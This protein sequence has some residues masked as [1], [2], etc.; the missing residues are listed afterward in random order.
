MPSD[1][2]SFEE[3]KDEVVL[4]RERAAA[5]DDEYLKKL[6]TAEAEVLS[7]LYGSFLVK[8]TT[9][10]SGQKPDNHTVRRGPLRGRRARLLR[11][12]EVKAGP[13]M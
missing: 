10:G 12:D 7:S 5:A 3:S 6:W 8:A 1:V 4:C 9:A 2:P 11:M 13:R